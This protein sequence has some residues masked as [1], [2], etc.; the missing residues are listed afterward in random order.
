MAFFEKDESSLNRGR[1]KQ[2]LKNRHSSPKIKIS[3]PKN[4]SMFKDQSTELKGC[5]TYC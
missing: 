1:T 3:G 5:G 2:Y 4:Q